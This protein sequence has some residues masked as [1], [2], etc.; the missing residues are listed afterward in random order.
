LCDKVVHVALEV[1]FWSR[2]TLCCTRPAEDRSCLH[3]GRS[4]VANWHW[5]VDPCW[6]RQSDELR[7]NFL[8]IRTCLFSSRT[9][10]EK[11]RMPFVALKSA[12][13]CSVNM[14]FAFVLLPVYHIT[15]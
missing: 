11:G 4:R 10:A 1:T 14:S 13:L 3:N 7:S 2:L 15:P 5:W 9:C 6:V 12:K 8:W